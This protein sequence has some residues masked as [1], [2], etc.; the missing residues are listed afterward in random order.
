MIKICLC[1]I[2]ILIA[3]TA[4]FVHQSHAEAYVVNRSISN[5]A[6]VATLVGTLDIPIGSYLIENEGESPFTDVNLTMTVDSVSFDLDASLTGII[7]DDGQ[8]FIEATSTSLTFDAIG[9]D[10]N[11]AD[12]VFSDNMD[13]FA[14]NRWVIGSNGSPA[15]EAARSD[16]GELL[17]N[18]FSFPVTFGTVVP[19]PSSMHCLLAILCLAIVPNV[20]RCCLK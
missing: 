20:R 14:N 11:P 8:F 13:P 1:Y 19:E 16:N 4:L 7:T 2:S 15:F 3:S 9:N 18:A 6:S 5:G 17:T 12:L 10:Q